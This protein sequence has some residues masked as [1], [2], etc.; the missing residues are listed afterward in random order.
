MDREQLQLR[1]H[2]ELDDEPLGGAALADDLAIA[3]FVREL[4]GRGHAEAFVGGRE[5][6]A[7]LR[8]LRPV[9]EI[10]P[11]HAPDRE[12]AL[13]IEGAGRDHE[14][15]AGGF[16]DASGLTDSGGRRADGR[17]DG[18]SGSAF[19]CAP[20]GRR[21]HAGRPVGRSGARLTRLTVASQQDDERGSFPELE[22]THP[23]KVSR[24]PK[25]ANSIRRSIGERASDAPELWRATSRL[26]LSAD[27]ERA[28]LRCVIGH[29]TGS[30]SQGHEG[31]TAQR[32][33]AGPMYC[34]RTQTGSST[35]TF[36]ASAP[37][38]VQIACAP[39]PS[40]ADVVGASVTKTLLSTLRRTW[41][42]PTARDEPEEWTNPQV[43][44]SLP[45]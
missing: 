9:R 37:I 28:H 29:A 10:C 45:L 27:A 26:S 34:P 23:G 30:L 32:L 8:P 40:T 17:I 13:R 38:H 22:A 36:G 18:K 44:T 21:R 24:V 6:E 41:S 19:A 12:D 42:M 16:D 31:T 1:C 5:E 3:S 14:P 20:H 39:P 35:F 2:L 4:D 25:A 15:G 7:G 33:M 43:Q 11:R